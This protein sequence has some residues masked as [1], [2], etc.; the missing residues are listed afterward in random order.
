M[1]AK[2]AWVGGWLNIPQPDSAIIV[3][4]KRHLAVGRKGDTGAAITGTGQAAYLLSNRVSV[5]TY[6][7]R[8][9]NGFN[10]LHKRV[11]H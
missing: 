2:G 11:A 9:P 10:G 8:L 4:Q 3:A 5:D 6:S 7:Q 1:A